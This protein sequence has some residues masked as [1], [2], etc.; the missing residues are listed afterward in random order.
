MTLHINL[1]KSIEKIKVT[2]DINKNNSNNLIA[3]WEHCMIIY[4]SS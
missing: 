2:N 3:D 4:T 1:I